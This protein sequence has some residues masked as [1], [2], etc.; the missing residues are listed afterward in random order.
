MPVWLS[1]AFSIQV[2]FLSTYK[3]NVPVMHTGW[4]RRVNDIRNLVTNSRAVVEGGQ[5]IMCTVH[6]S[7]TETCYQEYWR[8]HWNQWFKAMISKKSHP[9]IKIYGEKTH[10]PYK[11]WLAIKYLSTIKYYLVARKSSSPNIAKTWPVINTI[12][13]KPQRSYKVTH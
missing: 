6:R 4:E 2:V 12:Y 3:N 9:P 1:C 10:I 7:L 11:I 13:G 5:Y 8:S